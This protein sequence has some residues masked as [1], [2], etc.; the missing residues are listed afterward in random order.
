MIIGIVVAIAVIG[1][2]VFIGLPMMKNSQNSSGFEPAKSTTAST[3]LPTQVPTPVETT[4]IYTQ[5]TTEPIPTTAPQTTQSAMKTYTSPRFGFSID[6]PEGWEVDEKNLLET[7]S[8]TRYNVIEFHSP[9][10][11]RCDTDKTS[12]AMVRSTVMVE[13]ETSPGTKELAD[14]YVP[15]VAKITSQGGVEITKKDSGYKL[16]GVKAYRLDYSSRID[17]NDINVLSAYTLISNNAYI[18]TY[19]AYAPTRLEENQFE[20]YYN[21]VME[22]Y[23]SFTAQGAVKVLQ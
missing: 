21:T 10:I 7:P 13:V 14:Y 12:C 18:I 9:S 17:N 1:A 19:R 16:S 3:V 22:M 23:K 8:L 5:V 11:N 2:I 4:V 6:Y 20:L 15:Q